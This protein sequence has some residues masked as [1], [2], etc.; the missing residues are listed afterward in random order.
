VEAFV[1]SSVAVGSPKSLPILIISGVAL[2]IPMFFYQLLGL[3]R[4]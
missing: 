4:R 3:D 1:F 2:N